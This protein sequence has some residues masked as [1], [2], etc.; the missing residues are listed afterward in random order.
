MALR[1]V[2]GWFVR[3]GVRP[4]RFAGL[5][6]LEPRVLLSGNPLPTGEPA[7][8]ADLGDPVV[9]AFAVDPRAKE[10]DAGD[11][12]VIE[13]TRGGDPSDPLTVKYV[14]GGTA[15]GGSDYQPLSGEATF[16]P[17][18]TTTTISITAI[19]DALIEG[20]QSVIVELLD[21]PDYDLDPA[22]F[23][24]GV[25]IEDDEGGAFNA[26]DLVGGVFFSSVHSHGTMVSLGNG[27]ILGGDLENND[28]STGSVTGGDY[29]IN[30]DGTGAAFIGVDEGQGPE[31]EDFDFALTR[32]GDTAAGREQGFEEDDPDLLAFVQDTGEQHQL[33]D[34]TGDWFFAGE[35][36]FAQLAIDGAGNLSGD[37]TRDE[38]TAPIDGGTASINADG[39]VTLDVDTGDPETP[40][41]L[42]SGYLNRNR[43]VVVLVDAETN[44]FEESRFAIMVKKP[45]GQDDAFLNGANVAGFGPFDTGQFNFNNGDFDG[46]LDNFQGPAA[47][48]VDG[49]YDL[50]NDGDLNVTG[51]VT[52]PDETN[53]V[54]LVGAPGESGEF[55][56][57]MDAVILDDVNT[58]PF[59]FVYPS[60]RPQSQE[61]SPAFI[62]DLVFEDANGNGLQDQGEPGVD[63]VRVLLLDGNGDP[64]GRSTFTTQ[65]GFYQFAIDQPGDFRLRFETPDGFD[66]AQ[67]NVGADDTIDS[68]AESPDATTAP[69]AVVPGDF[70]ATIDAGLVPI[71]EGGSIGDFVWRDLDRD[72]VQD[73]GEPGLEGV[74]V[75]LLDEQGAP[76]GLSTTSDPAGAYLFEGVPAGSYLVEFSTPA[77]FDLSPRDQGPDD[78]ADSDPDPQTGVVNEPVV[79][80]EGSSTLDVDAGYVTEPEVDYGDAPAELGY[81]TVFGADG[82]RHVFVPGDPVLGRRVDGEPD[83]QPD[84]AALGD[85]TNDA[86][87]EDG[88]RF[89]RVLLAG[90]RGEVAVDAQVDP[91]VGA[92][93]DAWIDFN[94]DGDWSDPG[95]QVFDSVDVANGLNRLA[96]RVPADAAGGQTFGR[97]RL[98]SDG[99]LSPTGEAPD[100]EVEDH[101]LVV[102]LPFTPP[103]ADGDDFDGGGL[104][105][106]T[107][108]GDAQVVVSPTNQANFV[109][110]L[111]EGSDAVIVRSFDIPADSPELVFD[112]GFPVPGDGDALVV[113]V[114]PSGTPTE[115]LNLV[116]NAGEPDGLQ[117]ID[118]VD[119]AAWAGQSVEIEFRLSST[120]GDAGEDQ[121][122]VILDNIGVRTAVS[123]ALA[124]HL[125][126]NDSSFDNNDPQAN[127][128]DDD[129]IAASAPVR[130]GQEA[131]LANVSSY[132]KGI[133]GV[134]ID[135]LG[136]PDGVNLDGDDFGFKTGNDD[137][138]STWPAAPAPSTIALRPGEGVDGSDRITL[139]W[140]DADAVKKAWLEVTVLAN[141]D[142][143]LA[144]NEVFYYGNAVGEA[145]NNASDVSVDG[146]D[147]AGVRDNPRN[148]LDPAG[149][150]N[151]HDFNRDG[152]VDGSDFAIAR[153]NP[154]NFLT[155]LN[156]IEP[157]EVGG[158]QP[159]GLGDAGAQAAPTPASPQD[160]PL[161]LPLQSDARGNPAQPTDPDPEDDGADDLV[162]LLRP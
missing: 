153:D 69:F 87:D 89:T 149:L 52:D 142:T 37:V 101:R 111:R 134:M 146:S 123:A 110:S 27:V 34:L 125:F 83:G 9:E 126:F 66:L 45:S 98:S 8:D 85:D 32:D 158:L 109:V 19:D 75:R 41:A 65:G 118:P 49:E 43:D 124:H 93:L 23:R 94:N 1:S 29:F 51:T 78:A 77:G 38:G 133:N 70:D 112:R 86:F 35:S 25:A 2:V 40:Q 137:D 14:V 31:F 113:T 24:A 107:P 53:P 20:S 160:A 39:M 46:V 161:R 12:A 145:A 100:G 140:D 63:G 106:F 151:P 155:S 116:G 68:D 139:I 59:L 154:T 96:F 36:A 88:V 7:Q 10:A 147:L 26:A 104:G 127:A 103:P 74:T 115:V 67:S 108:T 21:G 144:Q 61:P 90:R 47:S 159:A 152:N 50:Q 162:D 128:D 58:F 120:G 48:T 114:D 150:T 80:D 64:T 121:G 131:T 33:S 15:I 56:A 132:F 5:E 72:G 143:R 44:S 3:R 95:E 122:Q 156:L 18:Q 6:T 60:D 157:P 82:A 135:I 79:V 97:F 130:P 76:T 17:D 99:G 141:D 92:K 84:P 105:S 55:V 102:E 4:G 28:G 54:D 129:A 81:P 62:G 71:P 148:F 11:E 91:Q 138:P 16:G 13:L 30:P 119:L 57:V 73:P 42:F 117:T 22:F 136:L